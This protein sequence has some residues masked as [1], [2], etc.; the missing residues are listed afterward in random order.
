MYI[1]SSYDG[2][3]DLQD[4]RALMAALGSRSGVVDFEENIQIAEVRPTVR[5]WRK[6]GVLLAFAMVDAFNNL[7]FDCLSDAVLDELGGELAAWGAACIRSRNAESGSQ[8]TLDFSCSANDSARMQFANQNGFEP[9]EVRSLHYA[10]SIEK[11]LESH[12]F[13]PGY[14]WRA[15]RGEEEVEA[16]V[17]LHRAAF[18]T[19]NMTVEERLAIMRAP[20]YQPGMDLVAVAPDGSL[21][22]FCICGLEGTEERVGYTDPIGVHPDHKGHGLAA[23]LVT[24][25]MEALIRAGAVRIEVGTSSEN[26]AM[27]RLA[28]QLGFD[29]VSEKVWFSKEVGG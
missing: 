19:D 4:M 7:W 29:L 21:A 20:Q 27:Q 8:D 1:T 10:R 25:G 18:G 5:L 17:A 3:N 11:P 28:Q 15:V 22:A 2:S 24:T 13:P 14:T 12:P 26:A 6:D 23:A 9:L 16:L